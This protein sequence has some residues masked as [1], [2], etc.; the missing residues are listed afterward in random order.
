MRLRTKVEICSNQDL[1]THHQVAARTQYTNVTKEQLGAHQ[2]AEC[3]QT[4]VGSNR[5]AASTGRRRRIS[6]TCRQ[7]VWQLEFQQGTDSASN[8][9]I[10]SAT[11]A[12][13]V[14]RRKIEVQDFH[15]QRLRLRPT[16]MVTCKFTDD[17]H[18]DEC[19]IY[20]PVVTR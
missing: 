15:A 17:V 8:T 14:L 13:Y 6:H 9:T 11:A 4:V 5:R 20:D 7:V 1:I 12:V 19:V 3:H 10:D 18:I 16:P 2:L